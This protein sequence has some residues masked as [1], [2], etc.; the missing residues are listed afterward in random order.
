MRTSDLVRVLALLVAVE[1]AADQT[2]AQMPPAGQGGRRS[3]QAMFTTPESGGAYGART[4]PYVDAHGNPVVVPAGYCPSCGGGGPAYEGSYEEG[5]G[6]EGGPSYGDYCGGPTCDGSCGQC[7]PPGN[8][9]GMMCNCPGRYGLCQRIADRLAIGLLGGDQRGPHYFDL[10]AE[11]VWLQRDE[12][13]GRDVVFTSLNV[14]DPELGPDVVLSGNDLDYDSTGGYR[15]VGRFDLCALSVL[16]FGYMGIDDFESRASFT[17]PEPVDEDTGNLYSLFSDFGLNPPTVAIEGGPMPET[18]RSI[19]HSI[20]IDSDL[21]TAEMSYRRYWIG[22][23]PSVSGT[24][25]AG[26]RYTKL[27]EEF[28]F[29]TVG[30]AAMSSSTGV[31]NN[32]AGFQTGGDIWICLLQGMRV[33]AEGKA[34]IY[35]NHY[36]VSNANT[37]D[38]YILGPPTYAEKF[39][40]D[41]V[42]FIGEASADIVL[43][44]LP[45]WSL[46]GGYEVLWLNSIVLAGENF[47]TA[48][49]Y[50]LPGQAPRIPF[51]DNQGEAFYHGWHAGLEFVW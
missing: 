46:R 49:P 2:L 19:R 11:T 40:D 16:E 50:G 32:L 44:L 18:E 6:Y 25:L 24:W 48:S 20:R 5:Y 31:D 30:E 17:D 33:G 1:I 29:N 9:Y 14:A 34:G 36:S 4:N 26:F 38:P 43:D 15:I 8:P 7:G 42:A 47:N 13:F 51:V 21:Q 28:S 12:T 45:S 22:Y 37:P 23:M 35:N 10:R 41:Q 27:N 3:M 39:K